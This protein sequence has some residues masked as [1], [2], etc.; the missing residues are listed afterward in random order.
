MM[1]VTW[2]TFLMGQVGLIRKLNYLDATLIFNR[3]HVVTLAS[4]GS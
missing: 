4:A 2:I 1:W 3:S